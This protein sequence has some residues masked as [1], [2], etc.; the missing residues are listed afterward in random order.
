MVDGSIIG[1]QDITAQGAEYVIRN[2]I[3]RKKGSGFERVVAQQR[4][5]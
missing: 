1:D 5:G 2:I 3:R 4:N